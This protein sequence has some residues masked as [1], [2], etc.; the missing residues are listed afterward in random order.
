MRCIDAS[1]TRDHVLQ[2]PGSCI[3]ICYTC[4]ACKASHIT[5]YASRTT[6][7]HRRPEYEHTDPQVAEGPDQITFLT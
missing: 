7:L 1:G 2:M 3:H 6:D 4:C 5:P